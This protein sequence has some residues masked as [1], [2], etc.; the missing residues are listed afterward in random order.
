MSRSRRILWTSSSRKA[1]NSEWDATKMRDW[2]DRGEYVICFAL[3]WRWGGR[4]S[5]KLAWMRAS[6]F[7]RV[8]VSSP[9]YRHINNDQRKCVSTYRRNISRWNNI[10]RYVSIWLTSGFNTW[11]PS[12]NVSIQCCVILFR[13]KCKIRYIKRRTNWCLPDVAKLWF[14]ILGIILNNI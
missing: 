12:C 4:S 11:S 8:S 7:V 10:Y 6:T 5:L 1:E 14:F 13:L 3:G 9:V 2:S